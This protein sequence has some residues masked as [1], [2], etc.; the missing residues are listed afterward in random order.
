[1]ANPLIMDALMS[2]QGTT[3][4][5]PSIL[6]PIF[7]ILMSIIACSYRSWMRLAHIPGPTAAHCSI[8]WLLRRAWIGELFPCMVEAGDQYGIPLLFLHTGIHQGDLVRIGPNLLLCSDPD[9]VRRIS[10]IR[11][12]YTKGPAYEAGRVTD[13]EPHVASQRDPQKHKALRAKMG[14][15]YSINIEPAIDRQMVSFVKLLDEKYAADRKTGKPGRILDFAKKAQFW[16]LDCVGDLCFGEP[17]GFLPRDEDVGGFA[18]LNDLSLRMVTAAGLV[19]WLAELKNTWPFNMLVPKEGDK[20]GFG[21]LFGYAKDLVERKTA[22]AEKLPVTDK[23]GTDMMQMFIRSGMSRHDL[24]QQ[25]YVHI[26]CVHRIA[27]ADA[28]SNVARMVM[29]CILTCPP[30][31]MALQKE[32]D[33][34][35]ARGAL[36]YPVATDAEIRRLPYLQAVIRE[37]LRRYPPSVSPSKVSPLDKVDTVCGYAVP[38]GTQIGANVP[39]MLRNKAIFGQDA[40]QYRP[41]RWIE[42]QTD[43]KDRLRRMNST[44]DLVFGAGKFQCLG[45]SVYTMELHKMLVELMR[46]FDF[47]LV[48]NIN[49]CKVE[50]LAIMVVHDLNVRVSRRSDSASPF[51]VQ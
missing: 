38:G 40:D 33:E 17:F 42:A 24:M 22:E 20:V 43:D 10:G 31:Y 39:G 45:K 46:R 35:D 2:A 48:D 37:A 21:I 3:T 6:I 12:E 41:E 7:F 1:M 47:A 4:P 16:S 44:V 11:S 49:P 32:I 15:A 25:V 19:P 5:S 26:V 23:P 34:A 18:R 29:L 30:V 9:E 13:G 50:S 8:L 28:S 14:P 36:R 27:G 51:G